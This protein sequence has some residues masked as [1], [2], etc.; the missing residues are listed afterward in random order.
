MQGL[1]AF[2]AFP[3]KRLRR[4]WPMR[5]RP[6]PVGA[7]TPGLPLTLPHNPHPQPRCA[8][9]RRIRHGP[10]IKQPS[11]LPHLRRQGRPIELPELLPLSEQQHSIR[12]TNGGTRIHNRLPH[13]LAL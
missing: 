3:S 13:A 7:N 6:L 9:R 5:P 11:G 12:S 2:T 1:R 8:R 10:G 4:A